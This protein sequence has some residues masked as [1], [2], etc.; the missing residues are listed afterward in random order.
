MA[1]GQNGW[2]K[3]E[4]TNFVSGDSPVTITIYTDTLHEFPL[5]EGYIA[6]DGTGNLLVEVAQYPNLFGDQFTIK[7]GEVITLGGSRVG[8]IRITHT[9]TDSSYRIV[10]APKIG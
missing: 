10:A 9:G 4:D 6:C 3:Q 1:I 5:V 8:Q 7:A 2:F